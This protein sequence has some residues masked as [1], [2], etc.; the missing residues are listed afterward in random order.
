[1]GKSF[2]FTSHNFQVYRQS[3]LTQLVVRIISNTFRGGVR[4]VQSPYLAVVCVLAVAEVLSIVVMMTVVE[5]G[6]VV[7]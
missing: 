7:D 1:M 3:L 2:F 6:G 4:N 5:G